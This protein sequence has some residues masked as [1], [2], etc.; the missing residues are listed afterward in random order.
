MTRLSCDALHRASRAIVDPH[1]LVATNDI[2]SSAIPDICF[3]DPA[4]QSSAAQVQ[5]VLTVLAGI[6]T[7]LTA[8]RWGQLGDKSGRNK[9]MSVALFGLVTA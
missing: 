9:A 4:V 8:G 7:A 2:S 3:T 1:L 6:L 5:M